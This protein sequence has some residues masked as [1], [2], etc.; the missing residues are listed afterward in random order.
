M[1][2]ILAELLSV[3]NKCTTLII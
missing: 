3:V 1:T 2:D